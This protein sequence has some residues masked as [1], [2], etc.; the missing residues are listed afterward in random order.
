MS[1]EEL[2]KEFKLS[3]ELTGLVIRMDASTVIPTA[4]PSRNWTLCQSYEWHR[5]PLSWIST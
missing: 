2:G 4:Q 1:T 3:D 5:N